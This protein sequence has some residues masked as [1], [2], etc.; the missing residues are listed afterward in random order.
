MIW[1]SEVDASP[2]HRAVI[3]DPSSIREQAIP[4]NKSHH[5]LP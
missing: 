1:V 5:Q 2:T 3:P 4:S